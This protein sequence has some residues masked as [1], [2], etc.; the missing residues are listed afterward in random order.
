MLQPSSA[1]PPATLGGA[2]QILRPPSTRAA[3]CEARGAVAQPLPDSVECGGGGLF[4]GRLLAKR[5]GDRERQAVDG[6]R[7]PR[8]DVERA[9]CLIYNAIMILLL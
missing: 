8:L 9:E 5:G 6:G 7:A 3:I 4:D 1:R 2:G